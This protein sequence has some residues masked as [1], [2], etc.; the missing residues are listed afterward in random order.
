M[1]DSDYSDLERIIR[2]LSELVQQG[3][4]SDEAKHKSEL[5]KVFF[6]RQSRSQA[7]GELITEERKLED[8]NEANRRFG[9]AYWGRAEA[10]NK[11]I[12]FWGLMAA[13]IVILLVMLPI[14]YKGIHIHE[15]KY[16]GE[17]MPRS[18]GDDEKVPQDLY[19]FNLNQILYS[20]YIGKI[21]VA[22]ILASVLFWVLNIFGHLRRLQINYY[23]KSV[24]AESYKQLLILDKDENVRIA[25]EKVMESLFT[26]FD[27]LEK[28]KSYKDEH[29]LEVFSNK[30]ES[31]LCKLVE[32]IG[33]SKE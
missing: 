22:I 27:S 10:L 4:P 8:K 6:Q 21:L 33:K 26:T 16:L 25:T 18:F 1:S 32:L 19:N 14:L 30:I 3:D 9:A 28:S 20:Y 24:I 11:V 17:I 12:F 2:K 5:E 29:L 31:L 7:A 13:L 23:D 15:I